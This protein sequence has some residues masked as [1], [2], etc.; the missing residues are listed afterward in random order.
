MKTILILILVLVSLII[1]SKWYSSILSVTELA[2]SFKYRLVILVTPVICVG[3]LLGIL[4]TLASYNV[5]NNIF[6]IEFYLL[7]GTIWLGVAIETFLFFGLSARDD[8]IE[9]NN[10]AAYSSIVGALIGV[11]FCFVGG[12]FGDKS[13]WWIVVYS[14]ILSTSTW[15]FLWL[16]LEFST[17]ISEV[18]TIDRDNASGLRLAG[19]LVSSSIIL[20]WAVAGNL[21]SVSA[22]TVNF[23]K[24]GWRAVILMMAAIIIEKVCQPTARKPFSSIITHGIIPLLAYI[25]ISMICI[26]VLGKRI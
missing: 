21:V 12:N 24:H 13:G 6:L 10:V 11:T 18:I 15:F 5:R 22:A 20:G 14:A 4:G 16:V 17:H 23:I 19:F 25:S 8:A 1:W 9:R 7:M 26:L 3:I 2:S